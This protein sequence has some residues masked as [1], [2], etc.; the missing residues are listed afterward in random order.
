MSQLVILWII[1]FLL[2][3]IL[4]YITSRFIVLC[5]APGS[6]ASLILSMFNIDLSIQLIVFGA[7]SAL[8]LL[9]LTLIKLSKNKKNK[10][11]QKWN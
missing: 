10:E 7:S 5:F 3:I 2:V 8:F 1:V 6:L 9:L 11:S 4:E